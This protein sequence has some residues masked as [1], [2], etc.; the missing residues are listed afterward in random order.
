MPPSNYLTLLSVHDVQLAHLGAQAERYF[1]D[2]PATAIFKLRQFA[3]PLSKTVAGCHAL[4]QG[5]RET[6][7]ETLGR[8]A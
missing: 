2:D 1:T 5:E 8:R 3:W 4:Y 6:F 7:E